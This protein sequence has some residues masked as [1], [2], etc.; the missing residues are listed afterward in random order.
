ME[1]IKFRVWDK[2]TALH[3]PR[4]IS[5]EE[6]LKVQTLTTFFGDKKS[7]RYEMLFPTG[8]FDKNGVEIY[9][10]DIVKCEKGGIWKIEFDNGYFKAFG[11]CE[12]TKTLV[13]AQIQYKTFEIIGNVYEY[14]NK[15]LLD[16]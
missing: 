1:D 5:F 4:M 2:G 14:E 3:A 12:K 10:G 6:A 15:E 7:D 8:L 11:V 13:V 16:V 9:R